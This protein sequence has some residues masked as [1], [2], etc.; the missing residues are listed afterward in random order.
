MRDRIFLFIVILI[1]LCIEWFDYYV[2]KSYSIIIVLIFFVGGYIAYLFLANIKYRKIKI[3]YAPDYKPFVS[4]VIAAKNEDMVIESTIRTIMKINYNKNDEGPN[5]EL[6]VAN[7]GSTDKTPEIINRLSKEYSNLRSYHRKPV[8][9]SNKAS[10]LNEVTPMCKG[11]IICVFDADARVNPD[12][13]ESIIPYFSDPKVGAVQAQKRLSN[14]NYNYLT[15]AQ[16]D[17]VL[18]LMAIEEVQDSVGGA[19]DLRGNGMLI[20]KDILISVGGWT[21]DVLTEDLDMSTKLHTSGWN[22]RFCPHIGVYE[23]GVTTIKSFL[24]QRQRWIEGSIR[25]YLTYFSKIM[26]NNTTW[27][28]KIYMLVFI[29]A[30]IFPIWVLIDILFLSY[31]ILFIK[32]F[33]FRISMALFILMISIIIGIIQSI[34]GLKL[35]EV[36]EKQKILLRSLC[37]TIYCLH[38]FPIVIFVFFKIMFSSKP[39]EWEKTEHNGAGVEI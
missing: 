39:S 31:N 29:F 7:D 4:I 33:E 25:R 8:E 35:A 18:M 13:L 5:Y 30:S 9:K 21:E 2:L 27:V 12:F 10:V 22:I 23:E 38:W 28:K 16:K 3:P 11:D 6:I 20:R 1:L 37:N 19:V 24:K 15:S 36:S 34:A 14:P 26:G 17:E 32:N